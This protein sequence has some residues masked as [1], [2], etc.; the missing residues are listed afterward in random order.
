VGM[1][2]RISESIMPVMVMDVKARN[3]ATTPSKAPLRASARKSARL[4]DLTVMGS[5]TLETVS[6]SSFA[7]QQELV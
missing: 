6:H 7:L 5:A 2:L 1:A 3:A 4:V